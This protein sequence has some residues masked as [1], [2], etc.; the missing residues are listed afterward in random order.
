M[1]LALHCIWLCLATPAPLLVC[2]LGEACALQH[3]IQWQPA[4]QG[5]WAAAAE[6][7]L[8]QPSTCRAAQQWWKARPKGAWEQQQQVG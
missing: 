8:L 2:S 1:E 3:S 7:S 5:E 4:A 6:G